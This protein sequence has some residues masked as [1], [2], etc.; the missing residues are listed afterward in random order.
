MKIQT[1]TQI[2]HTEGEKIQKSANAK[3]TILIRCQ[4]SHGVI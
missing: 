2:K 1:K 3:T 4:I